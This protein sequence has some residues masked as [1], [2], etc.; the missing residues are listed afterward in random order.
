MKLILAGSTGLV[1]TE[2]LR[3]C[4]LNPKITSV[5]ALTRRPIDISALA[6]KAHSIKTDKVKSIVLQ[7]FTEYPADVKRELA[8]ADA[9]IW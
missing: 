5:V 7:D 6:S 9:C 3:Q 2:V 4:L 8:D 1:G